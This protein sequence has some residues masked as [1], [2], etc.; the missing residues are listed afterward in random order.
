MLFNSL[1]FLFFFL[2]VVLVYFIL[3]YRFRWMWL[4]GA[5]CFFYMAFIPVYILVLLGTI[6]VDYFA[7]IYIEQSSGH[8]K[9]IWL[10]VSIC[11]TCLI[12]F[13]FKYFNFFNANLMKLAKIFDLHY[14]VNKL[15]LILPI[16]LS[17]HTFQSLSYVIEVYR[18]RQQ[19]ERHFGI[20][21]LYVMFFPQMV[22]GPIERPQNLL[23]QF[24]EKHHWDYNRIASGLKLML[25]GFFK[26]VVIADGLAVFVNQVYGHPGGFSAKALVL[27]TYFFSIQI[28]CDFSGYTDIARGAARVLGFGLMKNFKSPYLAATIGEFWQRWHISLS[29][30]FRDYLYIPLGGN[31]VPAWVWYRNLLIVFLISG[32]WH[33]ANWTF[34]CWG[35]LHGFYFI[36]SIITRDF[37][38][39]SADFFFPGKLEGVHRIIQQLI[40]FHLV[41]FAWIFFR[42]NSIADVALILKRIFVRGTPIAFQSIDGLEAKVLVFIV[43]CVVFMEWVQNNKRRVQD[44]L[45]KCYLPFRW[46]LYYGFILFV[47]LAGTYKTQQFIYFQF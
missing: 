29:T 31:R 7:A 32:L 47:L 46:A 36:F 35:C 16:G 30:W 19:A 26:K 44:F 43:V 25:W 45:F 3:P 2:T 10:I 4:L 5:S 20:Y 27:A 38:K 9:K 21:A 1:Q 15:S 18:G 13:I 41:T 22:A 12:L 37:R 24:Y 42:A 23:H 6:L 11:S 40:T 39:K 34:V 8:R 14:P 17:F 28:Y 33:G